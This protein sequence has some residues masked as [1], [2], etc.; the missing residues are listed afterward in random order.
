MVQFRCSHPAASIPKSESQII[1]PSSNSSRHGF[2]SSKLLLTWRCGHC[3]NLAP[4]YTKAAEHMAGIFTFA[5]VDCDDQQNRGLCQEFGIQ[6]FPTLKFM[7][8]YVGQ[9]DAT[10]ILHVER[11]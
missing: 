10:G 2:L 8:P 11:Y 4:A 1:P 7:K 6:G 3:K 9:V 5:A